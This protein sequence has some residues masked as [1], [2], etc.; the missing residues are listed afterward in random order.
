MSD[1][2]QVTINALMQA[3]PVAQEMY[4]DEVKKELQTDLSQSVGNSDGKLAGW[5]EDVAESMESKAPLRKATILLDALN[6]LVM[7]ETVLMFVQW[8]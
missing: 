6:C 2:V 1:I 4:R 5:I 7:L 8:Y 3:M